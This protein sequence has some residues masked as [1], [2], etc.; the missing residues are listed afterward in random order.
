MPSDKELLAKMEQALKSNDGRFSAA[1]LEIVNSRQFHNRR[2][3]A[4]VAAAK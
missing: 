3:E 2:A 4:T 1:V